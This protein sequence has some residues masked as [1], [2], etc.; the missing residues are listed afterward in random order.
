MTANRFPDHIR[1]AFDRHP[2]P[3][4]VVGWLLFLVLPNV[5][6]ALPEFLTRREVAGLLGIRLLNGA[7]GIGF[8]YVNY[9]IITPEVLQQKRLVRF[10]LTIVGMVAL[11]TALNTA[12]YHWFFNKTIPPIADLSGSPFVSESWLTTPIPLIVMALTSFSMLLALSSGL[13]AYRDRQEQER[14]HQ[15]M[16][17]EKKD[18]EL[19]AL[20]LQISPHFLFNTLNNVRYLARQQSTLTAD[21]IQRLSDMLRYM[22]YQADSGPVPLSTEIDYLNDYIALQQ[23]RLAPHNQVMFET[24]VAGSQVRIEPLLFIHFVENAFKYGIHHEEPSTITIRLQAGA[25]QLRFSV[26]NRRYPQNGTINGHESGIGLQNVQKRLA[27]HYPKRHQLDINQTAD[28]FTVQLTINEL[29][30]I[31]DSQQRTH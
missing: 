7:L 16:I 15:Q 23:L 13:A 19:N 27:L 22:I 28:W 14:R 31:H 6:F 30:T 9:Y 17:I 21:A 1:R 3:F 4:H 11:L 20:K 25:G 10:L 29:N 18:A 8:F 12:Y 24:D 2:Q 5:F 26:Q